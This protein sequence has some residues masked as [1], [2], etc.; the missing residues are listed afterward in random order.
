M[1]VF[2]KNPR[3]VSGGWYEGFAAARARGSRSFFDDRQIINA[4]IRPFPASLLLNSI[5]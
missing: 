5:L 1:D 2:S 4:L 3:G